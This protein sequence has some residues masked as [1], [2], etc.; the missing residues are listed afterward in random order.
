MIYSNIVEKR[1]LRETQ[2]QTMDEL[3]NYLSKSFGPYGSNTVIN[4]NGALPRYT[5]DGHTILSK[6]QFA[7]EIENSVL[8]DIQEE[9]RTQAIKVGD[10]TT[11]ITILSA[12]IF[13]ALAKYEED[14]E[15]EA[16]ITPATIVDTF[17]EIADEICEVIKSNG[18]PATIDDVYHIALTS[19]NGNTKLADMLKNVY[20]EFGLDVYID[21]KAS[22]NGTT[23]LK[24]INGMTMD[25]GFLDPTLINDTSKNSC[26]I[27]N[28]KIYAFKDPIDTMEMGLFLDSIL[29][30]NIVK[31]LNEKK[32]ENMIPTIIMAPRISRDYSSY[33]D[34]LM[35]LMA[36]ASA[37]NRGWLNI[38]TD[39]ASCDMEQYED[40]CDLCGCKPIKKYLDP[41]IQKEDI[42]NGIAPT[43]DNVTDFGG[44]AE[45][46]SSDANKTTFVT[47]KNMYKED[48]SY[49]ELFNQRIDYL[50]KQVSKLEVEGNK[51]TDIYTLKKRLNSLKG[52]MVEI[53]V[54]GVSV[55]DRDAERD[56]L[57]DAVLNCRSA[58]INGVGYG[59]NFEG[60]RA[61]NE[62]FE[63]YN[64]I[65]SDDTDHKRKIAQIISDAY[66][67]ITDLLYSSIVSDTS[68]LIVRSL[69]EHECPM[70][71]VTK[72]FDKSVLSSIDTDVCTINTISKIVTI[73]ATAN[74]F[75]LSTVNINKY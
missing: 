63:K 73:M 17:K 39:I 66:F 11:S 28:P 42:K 20:T 57:E 61:S 49:S 55:A 71:I 27:R 37:A 67:D 68:D 41:E 72:E 10:S 12:I 32:T 34:S 47:P 38:I 53:F 16:G 69:G 22:M 56:L 6:I 58:T 14:V 24:E 59:A 48:G 46:V 54:G 60:L 50:E 7:G 74:Q 3:K 1:S 51:T 43:P 15:N 8:A 19:T 5:K 9:T 29:Y 52:K 30:N 4:T 13:K 35:Q 44:S 25:C 36:N 23:Y 31:P 21:V 64:S 45:M 2:V 18:R 65:K 33:I 75:I 62:V 40:I 26:V 70:N